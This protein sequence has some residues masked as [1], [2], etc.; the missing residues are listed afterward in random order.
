MRRSKNFGFKTVK[1]LR[2][3]KIFVIFY[4]FSLFKVLLGEIIK[5][6][7]KV[8]TTI[9]TNYF[10]HLKTLIKFRFY[11]GTKNSAENGYFLF[12]F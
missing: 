2:K 11:P 7:K 9:D 1:N 3:W 4:I 6:I 12:Q 5:K 8:K 10:N